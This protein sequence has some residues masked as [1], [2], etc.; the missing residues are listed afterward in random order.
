MTLH[1]RIFVTTVVLLG[2]CSGQAPTVDEV[3]VVN[4]TEYTLD[5]EASGGDD[6]WLPLAIVPARSEE[7][8]ETI[9]HGDVWIFRFR[10]WGEPVGETSMSRAEL[11]RSGW[12]VEVP[13]E[14][15]ERLQDL[16]RPPSG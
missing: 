1:L 3:T 13:Q 16:G 9:D 8:R 2:A 7:T 6:Q 12:R 14:V 5:V 15:G 10:H 4:P 11:E